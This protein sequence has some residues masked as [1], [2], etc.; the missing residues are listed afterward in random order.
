MGAEGIAMPAAVMPIQILYL[1]VVVLCGFGCHARLYFLY[2]IQ[3]KTAAGLLHPA[4]VQLLYFVLP[5]K[6]SL[7]KGFYSQFDMP[8]G[9]CRTTG[10]L[11][12]LRSQM[13]RRAA[14][15]YC[16]QA[17][18]HSICPHTYA[19]REKSYVECYS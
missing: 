14:T 12:I 15:T 18:R 4:A 10:N 6:C 5:C 9:T 13:Q 11:F 7:Q 16:E 19:M 1:A 8:Y 2:C 17:A 3:Q